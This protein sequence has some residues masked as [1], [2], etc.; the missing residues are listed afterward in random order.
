MPGREQG[1]GAGPPGRPAAGHPDGRVQALLAERPLDH[2]HSHRGPAV[3]VGGRDQPDRPPE[4]PRLHLPGH[5]QR[6]R[7][8]PV[9][10]ACGRIGGEADGELDQLGRWP[11]GRGGGRRA[12]GIEG[13][14][15]GVLCVGPG[16]GGWRRRRVG[17]RTRGTARA[18]GS[19]QRVGGA[20]RRAPGQ[21]QEPFGLGVRRGA[22][23][24]VAFRCGM[25]RP[26]GAVTRAACQGRP[27]RAGH[28]Y[29][30]ATIPWRCGCRMAPGD[31]ADS[32]MVCQ[33]FDAS[34]PTGITCDSRPTAR[35]RRVWSC[36]ASPACERSATA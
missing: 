33:R 1:T 4:Q 20:G 18:G 17:W 10:R 26:K 11:C 22:R 9:L 13:A 12:D 2:R 24:R 36:R 31:S 23:A 29:G 6:H 27:V 34:V 19:P 21:A 8:R 7:P 28:L 30:I 5:Q 14:H 35:P 32:G 16:G 3:A 25:A 15:A